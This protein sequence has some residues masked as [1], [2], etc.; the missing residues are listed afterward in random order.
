MLLGEANHQLKQHFI[1]VST[2]IKNSINISSSFQNSSRT[3]STF[4]N[5]FNIHHNAI[6]YH[7]QVNHF[8]TLTLYKKKV[9]TTYMFLMWGVPTRSH[10]NTSMVTN[11]L[12][13]I[14]K[15]HDSSPY[16][17]QESTCSH[18]SVPHITQ[19]HNAIILVTRPIQI[20]K[21]TAEIS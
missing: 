8:R 17:F 15:S 16:I 3:G 9:E 20:C 2:F 7:L 10:P 5:Q 12:I 6:I 13:C 14:L 11:Q 18:S 19:S 1:V 21:S 4:H